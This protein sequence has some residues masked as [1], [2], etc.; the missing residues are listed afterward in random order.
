MGNRG[1]WSAK[2]GIILDA[3]SRL[4]TAALPAQAGG[5]GSIRQ[6]SMGYS[7]HNEVRAALPFESTAAA[8]TPT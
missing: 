6:D 4:T 5:A 7:F 8:E 3:E 2:L 1:V